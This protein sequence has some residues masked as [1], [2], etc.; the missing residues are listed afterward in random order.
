MKI[1]NLFKKTD[2]EIEERI[3]Q[4]KLEM[5]ELREELNELEWRLE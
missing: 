5:T 4:I 3:E 1:I 2:K